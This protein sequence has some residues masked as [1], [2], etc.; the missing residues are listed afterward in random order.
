MRT[1]LRNLLDLLTAN[2]ICTFLTLSLAAFLEAYGDSCFQQGLYRSNGA[3]RWL[4]FL[5]GAVVLSIYGLVVNT[6]RW[7][8]GRLLGAYVVLFFFMVQM[9]A[10]LRF[11]QR[12]TA[13]ILLGGGL[14]AAGGAVITFWK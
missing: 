7:D 3:A 11:H 1:H 13:P 9:L 8:F 6:P 12:P 14:I 5:G 10:W 4:P 2:P